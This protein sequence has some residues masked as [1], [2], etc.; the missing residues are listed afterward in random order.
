MQL[1]GI[2]PDSFTFACGLKACST[3]GAVW[4][5]ENLHAE[6]ERMG[7]ARSDLFIGNTL[8]D[9]YVKWGMATRAQEVFDKLPIQE[10]VS[11]TAL[12]AGYAENTVGEEAL[13]LFE[14]MQ[15][16]AA[17]PNVATYICTLKACGSIMAS[18]KGREIHAKLEGLDAIKGDLV[19]ANSL[20]DMYAKCGL[21]SKAQEVFDKVHNGDVVLWTTLI[22]GYVGHGDA[23]KALDCFERMHQK[24]LAA[25]IV[26]FVSSL[27]ACGILGLTEK[28]SRI[29]AEAEKKGY[30]MEEIAVSN[31]LVDMYSKC[32]KVDEAESVFDRISI[33]NVVSWNALITGYVE[34]GFDNEALK[35][36]EQMQCEGVSPDSLTCVC[37]LRACSN[38]QWLS[39]GRWL[40]IQIEKRGLLEGEDTVGNTLVDM[41][42]KCGSMAEAHQIFGSLRSRDIVAW[43]SLIGGYAEHG[44]SQEALKLV[45]LMQR[46]G[47]FPNTITYLYSLKA[48][49][50]L[51]AID[52]GQELHREIEEYGLLERDS[53]LGSALV[54][55][56]AKCDLF[57]KAIDVLDK[58]QTKDV[59]PWTAM[60]SGYIDQGYTEEAI[61]CFEQM[62]L[63]GIHPNA[64]TFVSILKACCC[65]EELERGGG[66]HAEIER[67]GL[68]DRNLVIGNALIDMYAK[69]GF[70]ARAEEVF[71]RI[72]VRNVVTW[73][74]LM[75]GYIEH[76][77]E[78]K[79]LKCFEQMQ[80]EGISP[81]SLTFAC[82]LRACASIGDTLKAQEI[83]A[84]FEKKGLSFGDFVVNNVLLEMYIKL[85]S[86]AL[87]EHVFD[88]L[89]TQDVDSWNVLLAGYVENGHVE[90]ALKCFERMQYEGVSPNASSLVSS[91]KACGSV[92][93]LQ[94]GYELHTIVN[95]DGLFSS[96][97]IGNTLLNMYAKCGE[98]S[99]AQEVFDNLMV[100][101]VVSW[102]ALIARYVEHNY[103]EEALDCFEQMQMSGIIPDC[104]TYICILKACG[105]VGA[106]DKGRV[107]HIEV[108]KNGLPEANPILGNTLVYMYAI[109]GALKEAESVLEKLPL[110]DVVSWNALIAGY[111]EIGECGSV[112]SCFDRMLL[113]KVKPDS[114]SFLVVLNV[115]NRANSFDE[116]QKFFML[117]GAHGV[118]PTLDH[119]TCVIDLC[120]RAG[121]LHTAIQ[122]IKEHPF[123]SNI[124]AWRTLLNLCRRLG[125]VSLGRH[126]FEHA[127]VLNSED[128][129]VSNETSDTYTFTDVKMHWEYEDR[130]HG[131]FVPLM[132]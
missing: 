10:V 75:S 99:K 128:L 2:C 50:N 57:T 132:T 63:Q 40:H 44:Y 6:V 4:E 88:K 46:C 51:G 118:V 117:M 14:R 111:A 29:H 13:R 102:T 115:C 24:G 32:G 84:D 67:R 38:M 90:K 28:G 39:K 1:E 56:Y 71:D 105:T 79:A 125:N 15:M 65:V 22:T 107:I 80:L 110:R 33:L 20:V 106:I 59:V 74:S 12:I 129:T 34:N 58:I 48:C 130:D 100:Q 41:Y 104:I 114:V 18:D 25:D 5:G 21:L 121:H 94:M 43:N 77:Q 31:V 86:S 85:G 108:E 127:L 96:D 95:N 42:A 19:A 61:G 89:P 35:C 9:M 8:V 68:L 23:E 3:L 30:V 55:M 119:I 116:C 7:L 113:D 72:P 53:S 36:F 47:I 92:G 64:A 45:E 82:G 101:N 70:P 83:H 66:I 98:M 78:D 123:H 124:V 60:I 73:T 93:A 112:F 37:S 69:C 54:D 126:I 17:F 131:M 49:T 122:L 76:G 97:F 16:E 62:Q 120:C 91:L 103:G 26:S 52:K 109:C 11:W 87:A 27:K 81:D